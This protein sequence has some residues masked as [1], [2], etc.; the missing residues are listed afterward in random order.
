MLLRDVAQDAVGHLEQ[1]RLGN[2]RDVR[3][4]GH[5]RKERHLP[6]ER[7]VLELRERQLLA[8]DL[9]PDPHLALGDDEEAPS[10]IA[11]V[12]DLLPRT[13]PPVRQ[14]VDQLDR[15]ARA[16]DVEQRHPRGRHDGAQVEH[17]VV[18]G[19]RG[20]V[21]RL[22]AEDVLVGKVL[23]SS[24]ELERRA[25]ARGRRGRADRLFQAG[26]SAR[27]RL[28]RSRRFAEILGGELE[29]AA[30]LQG[31]G[32]RVQLVGDRTRRIV[33]VERCPAIARV[34]V[35][36]QIVDRRGS[37]RLRWVDAVEDERA[38]PA[39]VGRGGSRLAA[40]NAPV[41]RERLAEAALV[42]LA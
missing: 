21:L 34:R 28:R 26:A 23:Q 5:P 4:A 13:V 39:S 18:I 30:R 3:G 7:S 33:A 20:E 19:G 8:V 29:L 2:G 11:F 12:E 36:E 24:V 6:E 40:R 35:F 1:L 41:L 22:V 37:R 16:E 17:L 38:G 31:T 14:P 25:T 9:L 10:R 15:L 32:A 42:Q 27:L